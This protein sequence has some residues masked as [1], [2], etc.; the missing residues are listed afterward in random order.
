MNI[1]CYQHNESNAI[2]NIRISQL[3]HSYKNPK[4]FNVQTAIQINNM[5]DLMYLVLQE[6]HENQVSALI[7]TW[8][9]DPLIIEAEWRIYVSV[10]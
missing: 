9:F 8:T 6:N 10:N 7:T 2:P 4:L 1:S 3:W 5:N